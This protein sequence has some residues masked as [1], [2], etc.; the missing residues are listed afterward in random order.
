M[1]GC[2]DRRMDR[3]NDEWIDGYAY[4]H[5]SILGEIDVIIT[6]TSHFNCELCLF[7]KNMKH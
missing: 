7:K 5:S 3:W 4:M 6:F 2:I 1:D